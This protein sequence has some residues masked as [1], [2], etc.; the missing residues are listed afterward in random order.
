MDEAFYGF[1]FDEVAGVNV[2]EGLLEEGVEFVDGGESPDFVGREFDYVGCTECSAA[3][4][5]G[6]RGE[7][8]GG[9][10]FWME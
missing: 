7:K 8:Q 10:G 6:D 9:G 2:R 5:W 3:H 4:A 1:F